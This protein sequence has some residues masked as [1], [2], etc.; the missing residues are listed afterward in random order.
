M[1]NFLRRSYIK[2]Y[3][4]VNHNAEVHINGTC[5]ASLHSC[6]FSEKKHLPAGG[7]R[8]IRFGRKLG[9]DEKVP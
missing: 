6:L 1:H 7:S 5:Y 2:S 8:K 4:F 9:F 3:S